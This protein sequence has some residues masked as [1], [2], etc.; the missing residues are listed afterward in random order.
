[1]ELDD[2][3][4]R[5]TLSAEE[6]VRALRMDNALSVKKKL[7]L[8]RS[9]LLSDKLFILNKPVFLLDWLVN[10]FIR[11]CDSLSK[12]SDTTLMT[13]AAPSSRDFLHLFPSAWKFF[14]SLASSESLPPT[15]PI[16]P[17]L[18][19]IFVSAIHTAVSY[20]SPETLDASKLLPSLTRAFSLLFSKFASSFRVSIDNY[21]KFL[22]QLV[23]VPLNNDTKQ[24]F[25]NFTKE[26]FV[27]FS[28]FQ[29]QQMNQKKV[30]EKAI[31]FFFFFSSQNS[32]CATHSNIFFPFFLFCRCLAH[33]LENSWIL[34]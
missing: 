5:P 3:E 10:A 25:L 6:V 17:H 30:D 1:M 18:L 19:S 9:V 20:H 34:S 4:S 11:S 22:S 33:L 7:R 16:K 32:P 21:I 26:A 28:T 31:G 15:T 29:R 14:F 13:T 27:V 8:A 12:S 23:Q 24:Q 2:H